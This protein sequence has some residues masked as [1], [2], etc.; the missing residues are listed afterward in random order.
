MCSEALRS[1]KGSA[2]AAVVVGDPFV[3]LICT[4]SPPY[5]KILTQ[6]K[7]SINLVLAY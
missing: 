3:G 7:L 5:R 6:Y 1:E 4:Q 2:Q